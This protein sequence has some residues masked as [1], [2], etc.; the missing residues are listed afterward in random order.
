MPH[1]SGKSLLEQIAAEYPEIPVIVMTATNDLPTA[2]QC[3]RS[4]ASDYLLKP[5]EQN[6]LVAAV[7]RAV[8]GSVLRAEFLSLKDRLSINSPHEPDGFAD[9][10][11]QSPAIFAIFRYIEAIAASPAAGSD[12]RRNRGRQRVDRPRFA[13]SVRAAR[14]FGGGQRRQPSDMLFGHAKVSFTGAEGAR[15]G[16]LASSG[17]G[18]LFLEEIGDLSIASQVKLL[19]LLQDGS[20]Y[21]IGA[22]HRLNPL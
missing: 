20:F 14:R 7:L 21:P 17:E 5:V 19:R 13:S 11:T 15:D 10:V 16:L 2:V 4:G 3:M 22:D 8:E 9:I 6:C 18:T 12:H 1:L